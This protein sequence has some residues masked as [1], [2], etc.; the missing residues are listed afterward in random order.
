MLLALRRML[1]GYCISPHLIV[2]NLPLMPFDAWME[3]LADFCFED[4]SPYQMLLLPTLMRLIMYGIL[5]WWQSMCSSC[6]AN[7]NR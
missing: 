2:L 1:H 4:C 6:A 3:Y 7:Q 5:S